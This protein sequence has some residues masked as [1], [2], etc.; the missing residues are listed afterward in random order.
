MKLLNISL[1]FL[2]AFSTSCQSQ[3]KKNTL[4]LNYKAQTRG[5]LYQI[6]LENNSIEINNNNTI[7][8]A[9]LA[10]SQLVK[11][12]S[13][14]KVINFKEIENNISINDLAVDRAI[15]GV[16]KLH[17]NKILYEFEFNHNKL[18]KEIKQLIQLL[19]EFAQ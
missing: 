7:K 9:A 2:L 4:M 15:K 1:L 3:E 14:L 18:P 6:Q 5:Y 12:N 8:T 19:E 16:F 10:K 17:F 11:I 13:L